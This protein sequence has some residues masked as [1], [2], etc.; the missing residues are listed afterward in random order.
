MTYVHPRNTRTTKG[1]CK[2]CATTYVWDGLPRH[3][4][5]RCPT[6][7][8][9]LRYANPPKQKGRWLVTQ[10]ASAPH[11]ALPCRAEP[12][13]DRCHCGAVDGPLAC[14]EDGVCRQCAA[15]LAAAADDNAQD[16][17]EQLRAELEL[18][19]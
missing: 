12:D 2:P 16:R 5:A 15:E 1:R 4:D 7:G 3:R 8:T 6:C 9:A 18:D 19:P 11:S 17:A 10:P 14:V 13:T